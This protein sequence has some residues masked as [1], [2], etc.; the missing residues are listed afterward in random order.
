ME[1]MVD[2]A[3]ICLIHFYH[4]QKILIGYEDLVFMVQEAGQ[5]HPSAAKSTLH[6]YHALH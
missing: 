5:K 3:G 6:L 1:V 2:A 4:W